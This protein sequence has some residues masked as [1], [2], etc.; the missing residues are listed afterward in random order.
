MLVGLVLDSGKVRIFLNR[1]A[2]TSL[3][4]SASSQLLGYAQLIGAERPTR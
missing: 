4:F 3:G 2:M 1:Q